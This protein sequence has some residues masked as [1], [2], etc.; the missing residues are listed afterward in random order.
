MWS[1]TLLIVFI[2]ICTALLGEGNFFFVKFG[3]II[4]IT[5]QKKI[6]F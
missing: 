2:S 4:D 6:F 1:D 5:S 3:K